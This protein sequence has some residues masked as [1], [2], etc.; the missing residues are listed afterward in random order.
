M[1]KKRLLICRPLDDC[2]RNRGVTNGEKT[3]KRGVTFVFINRKIPGIFLQSRK[4][5]MTMLFCLLSMTAH[6]ECTPAPDCASIG[7]TETSCETT[8]L[9]CPFDTT[10]LYCLPCDSKY[11]YTCSGT[12]YAGGSG[13]SCGGKYAS[14]ECGSGFEWNDNSCEEKPDCTVGMIYYSDKSCSST[15]DNSKT[16]IGVVVKYNELVLS[17]KSSSTMKW[18]TYGTNV[19]GLT[20]ITSTAGAIA[21]YNGKA[22]TAAIIAGDS[23]AVAA[24]Y[25]ND[26]TTAGTSAG[27]WYLPATG[28]LYSYVY[29]NYNAINTAM[30]S[31]GWTFDS[32]YFWSSSEYSSGGVWTVNSS[33]GRMFSSTNK[34]A[35]DSVVCILEI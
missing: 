19:S 23:G 25:C 27:D 22:N 3:R 33:S 5:G 35:Y 10:K 1:R 15:Y 8:S 21:D 20:D 32:A 30:T 14:C 2:C 34:V 7:Y 31:I 6:A 4:I 13:V 28:E 11:Q 17:Q 9:K 16:A 18:G 12:G 24:K 26:Y 29:G